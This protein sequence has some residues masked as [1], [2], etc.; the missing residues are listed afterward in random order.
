M[1]G[2][3]T[4]NPKLIPQGDGFDLAFF[5]DSL[6]DGAK[7]TRRWVS[8]P[9]VEIWAQQLRCVDPCTSSQLKEV[10]ADSVPAAFEHYAREAIAFMSDLSGG[11]MTNP[12]ITMKSFTVGTQLSQHEVSNNIGDVPRAVE[13][14]AAAR[15]T[16]TQPS[17]T[18]PRAR[19]ARRA[20]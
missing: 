18:M 6:R 3:T 13:T 8:Q 16:T 1:T 9:T 15:F 2:S 17:A 20:L 10:T 7:G 12:V 14:P 4:I 5:D 19:A 11:V